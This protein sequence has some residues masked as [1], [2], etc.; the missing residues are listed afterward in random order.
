MIVQSNSNVVENR[1]GLVIKQPK[2]K[3]L[4]SCTKRFSN[5]IYKTIY[6][7]KKFNLYILFPIRSKKT[8]KFSILPGSLKILS[9]NHLR[10]RKRSL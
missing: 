1:K 6:L 8:S 4:K 5:P 2:P 9:V 3:R 10:H 7:L